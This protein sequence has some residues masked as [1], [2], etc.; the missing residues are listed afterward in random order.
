MRQ[1]VFLIYQVKQSEF[2]YNTFNWTHFN[3]GC[4][5]ISH[6]ILM[7]LALINLPYS[8]CSWLVLIIL[9]AAGFAALN[10]GG[11]FLTEGSVSIANVFHISKAV[12]GLTIVSMATSMPEMITSLLAAKTSP[13]L[14]IGN[15]LGSNI[16]NI[17]LILGITALIIP[18]TVQKRLI[19]REMPLLVAISG[20]FILF[21]VGGFARWEGFTML[22]IMAIY[23][24]FVVRWAKQES[25]EAKELLSES[26]A[27][28]KQH[29]PLGGVIYI[30]S[31]GALLALGADTLV[32]SSVEIAGRLGI[33]DV[34][35]GL[36]LVAIGTSLPELSASISA[37]RSGHEDICVGN[38]I[39]SN[40]FNILLIGGG[41]ASLVPIPVEPRLF[42]IEFPAMMLITLIFLWLA[43]RDRQISGKEG[44]FLLF[45]YFTILG[46]SSYFQL[47]L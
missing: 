32:N 25:K 22:A 26:P 47:K 23:L 44:C 13:G 18:L 2:A 4:I 19:R 6:F 15:I 21:A 39:G 29:S 45:L 27:P 43:T 38:I 40:L 10:Y 35:V 30:V 28:K 9:L 7:T 17:G 20:L 8:N 36:T 31:G 3:R 24:Y 12:I 16:A 33:S 34:L 42:R 14:A 11:D 41:V 37:A 1:C 5:K 46:L